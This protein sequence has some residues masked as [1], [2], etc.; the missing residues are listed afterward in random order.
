VRAGRAFAIATAVSLALVA[1]GP[2]P[3]RIEL[4]GED[5]LSRI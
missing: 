2:L 5:D 4:I 1:T 3:R